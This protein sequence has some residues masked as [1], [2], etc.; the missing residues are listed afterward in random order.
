VRD[1]HVGFL[2]RAASG[3]GLEASDWLGLASAGFIG[4][5]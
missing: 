1:A 3:N 4:G 5:L 2:A